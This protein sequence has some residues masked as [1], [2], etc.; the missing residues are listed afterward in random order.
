MNDRWTAWDA[1]LEATPAAGFMQS[2][3]WADFRVEAGYN[4]FAAIL[5]HQG[6]ILGGA[7]VMKFFPTPERC[8]YYIP[9]GPLLPDDE[10]SAREVFAALLAAI[11]AE[12]KTETLPIS[13]LRIE[14]RWER[15]PAFISGFRGVPAFRDGCMEPRHTL[16]V[17]LRPAEE[18]ILA[19]MKPKGRYNIRLAQKHGVS[20]VEDNSERGLADFLAIYRETAT[21]QKLA[22]KPPD[23]FESLHA[24]LRARNKGALFFAEHAGQRLAAALVVFFGWR[25]TY[26]FGGSLP[27]QRH[28][29]APHL[30]HWEIMRRA[31][32]SGHQCYDFWGIAPAEEPTHPWWD[33]SVFKRKFGG[34][35][36]NLVPTL[37][38]VYDEAAYER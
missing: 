8:F 29:M 18:Q 19:Q 1:F 7:V 14:P 31:K 26:F 13:H 4:H 16:W 38:Y 30:L 32:A 25:A 28:L 20:V 23:Y 27:V 10:S 22:A 35:E 5:K 11:E 15:L 17:D 34:R 3:W 2:S 12:R 21:R 33:I 6:A 37:D 24:I 36:I 9:D